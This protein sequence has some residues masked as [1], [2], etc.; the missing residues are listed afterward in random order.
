LPVRA[1]YN[2]GSCKCPSLARLGCELMADEKTAQAKANDS[3][4]YDVIDLM[5]EQ[6]DSAIVDKLKA[7]A[8]SVEYLERVKRLQADLENL[9]KMTK[10]EIAYVTRLAN[11]G[12]IQKLLPILDSLQK[13]QGIGTEN[14]N[15]DATEMLVGI[16][17]LTKEMFKALEEEGLEKIDT[18]EALF[19]PNLHEAASFVDSTEYP[20]GTI[21]KELR[22][23]YR[24]RGRVIRPSMVVVA[25]KSGRAE[26]N[27]D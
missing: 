7:E 11:E 6:L 18:H 14:R 22:A 16:S 19:D 4:R 2:S 1:E 8:R 20:D 24:V 26:S 3:G 27:A 15:V 23:G 25:R 5:R 13:A 17:L 9:Q 10:R 21:V 12:L